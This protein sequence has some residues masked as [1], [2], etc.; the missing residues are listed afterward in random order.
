MNTRVV[1]TLISKIVTELM[2]KVLIHKYSNK[3]YEKRSLF[4]KLYRYD[5]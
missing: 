4:Q 2:S 3:M 5:R 1:V